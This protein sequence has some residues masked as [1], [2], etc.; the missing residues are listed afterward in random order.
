MI[1]IMPIVVPIRAFHTNYLENKLYLLYLLSDIIRTLDEA[2]A[3][4]IGNLRSEVWNNNINTT[5]TTTPNIT[6]TIDTTTT[7]TNFNTDSS[8]NNIDPIDVTNTNSGINNK[9]DN[10]SN[11]CPICIENFVNNDIIIKLKC[12][13]NYHKTCITGWITTNANNPC[14]YCRVPIN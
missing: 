3:V 2:N 8:A 7:N 10:N 4:I 5:N 14:P 11:M 1:I 6:V 12:G 9:D 13:H